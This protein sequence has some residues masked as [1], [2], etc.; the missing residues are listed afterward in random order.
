MERIGAPGLR[1]GAGNHDPHRSLAARRYSVH[2]GAMSDT[3]SWFRSIEEHFGRHHTKA[4]EIKVLLTTVIANQE[5]LLSMSS[6]FSTDLA[7]QT[8]AIQALAAEVQ[9]GLTVNA[10][11]I[12]ALKDQIA[13][14][15]TVSAADLAT[16]EGNTKS[17]Q[18]ATT[19][20]QTAL[21]PVPTPPTP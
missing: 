2:I 11:A 20:L 15:G 7:A 1:I 17:I 21:N 8:A 13:A 4:D 19:A 3:S 16:L 6:T 10:A 12:Q 9:N 14:G 5:R 18:D